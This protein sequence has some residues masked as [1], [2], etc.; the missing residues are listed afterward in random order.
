MGGNSNKM[1]E[2]FHLEG[3]IHVELPLLPFITLQHTYIGLPI[4]VLSFTF[5]F[6]AVHQ[7]F[8]FPHP[9][10]GATVK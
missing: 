3:S 8:N 4:I 7:S 1:L 10:F 6:H 2:W 5:F 9:N